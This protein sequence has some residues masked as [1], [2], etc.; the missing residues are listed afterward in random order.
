V[1][2]DKTQIFQNYEENNLKLVEQ[3][4]NCN[5]NLICD[6]QEELEDDGLRY[7]Y[8]LND[9][10]VI[11][12]LQSKV[13]TLTKTLDEL[14]GTMTIVRAQAAGYQAKKQEKPSPQQLVA[15]SLGFISEYV[16][17]K[18]MEMLHKSLGTEALPSKVASDVTIEENEYVIPTKYGTIREKRKAEQMEKT[19]KE[20]SPA[21]KRR[22]KAHEKIDTK[23]NTTLDRFLIKKSQ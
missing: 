8:R 12:W 6:V 9:S 3:N 11:E 15:I 5:L 20:D 2:V 19:E 14:P 21:K 1:F 13:Q 18:W 16:G 4:K 7:F 23:K 22:T 17:K 10:K